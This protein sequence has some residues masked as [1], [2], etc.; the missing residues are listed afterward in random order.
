MSKL[1]K[2]EAARVNHPYLV[3]LCLKLAYLLCRDKRSSKTVLLFLEKQH[4]VFS[5]Q[6]LT[7]LLTKAPQRAL[8]N[9]YNSL[10]YVLK[11]YALHI[12]VNTST[13]F[14]KQRGVVQTLVNLLFIQGQRT[15]DEPEFGYTTQ[16]LEQ[17][18][19]QMLEILGVI[20]FT[21][22]IDGANM[23]RTLFQEKS[24][25]HPARY[26]DENGLEL[27]NLRQLHNILYQYAQK[28][29]VAKERLTIL[30]DEAHKWNEK[31]KL[32]A[33]VS[34][35]FTGWQQIVEISLSKCYTL[36]DKDA[37][38]RV[39]YEMAITLCIKFLQHKSM[40]D[41]LQVMLAQVISRIFVK[42]REQHQLVNNLENGTQFATYFTLL[43]CFFFTITI[44]STTKLVAQVD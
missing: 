1:V 37:R 24:L 7:G 39:L 25:V 10:A 16:T 29:Q 17:K 9:F 44:G 27:L 4:D 12:F 5:Y 36:L 3:E 38:E 41:K 6:F 8:P 22:A 30:F 43:R 35:C 32:S 28:S 15:S 42:L 31:Q 20:D 2:S 19:N 33:A 18:R 14:Y 21:H 34:H 13:A 40:K 11:I 26:R 23:F